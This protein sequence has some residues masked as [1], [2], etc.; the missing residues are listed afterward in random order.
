MK[1]RE[2]NGRGTLHESSC[3]S[4]FPT[5][6]TLTARVVVWRRDHF[7]IGCNAHIFQHRVA[8][9]HVEAVRR[10]RDFGAVDE[11]AGGADAQC[12]APGHGQ[13]EEG[14][15]ARKR[16]RYGG[17]GESRPQKMRIKKHATQ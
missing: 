13:R 10:V 1:E 3:P 7:V 15:S 17:R 16:A 8:R 14:V 2:G 4:S 6:C 9:Q 11:A 5:H 12:A